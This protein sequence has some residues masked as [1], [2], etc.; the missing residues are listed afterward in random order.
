MKNIALTFILLFSAIMVVKADD[1]KTTVKSEIKEVT[2]FINGAQ[3]TRTASA[4][5]PAGQSTFV[6]KGLSQYL[7]SNSVQVKG[8]GDFT[9][10]S[11]TSQL[12]YLSSQEKSK[13][14]ITLSDSL[15]SYNTQLEYQ[16]G[17]IEV[18]A[19][20][21]NMIIA[22]QAIGG[23]DN[24]VKIEDLKA[25]AEFFR[26][27]LADIKAKELAVNA[28][29]KKIQEKITNVTNQLSQMNSEKNKPTSEIIL[30]VTSKA[31]VS[32]NFEI[33]YTV[34]G[35][36]WYPS[37]DLRA[38]DASSPITLNYR[39]NVYQTT[40][41]DWKNITLTLSSGNPSQVGTKPSL[42]PWYLYLYNPY[43]YDYRSSTMNEVSMEKSK[44]QSNGE[45]GTYSPAPVDAQ[46]AASYTTVDVNATNFEFE[47][48]L[49]YTITSD[50]KTTIVDIQNYTLPATYQYYCAPK[51]DPSAFLLAKVTGWEDYNLLSG[52]INLY[53]EG[54]YV[55]KSYLNVK[56]TKD[57]LD[58]SL[59]RD[60]NIV[61]E[62][63][64]QKEYNTNQFIGSNRKVQIAWEISVRNKKKT[65]VTIV[66]EDQLPISTD[67]QIEV[68][69]GEISDA[70]YD[71]TNGFLKWKFNL[72]S[73]E[74][75]K[76][77]FNYTVKY[78]KDK[79]VY[80]E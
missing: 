80:I 4:T 65:P 69:K 51:L 5:V 3:V 70:V 24:G 59:G 55:G 63:K 75:K 76:L 39:A 33:S 37:Y 42:Y 25:A 21:K 61:V 35:A 77:D 8:T 10:L 49:P 71:E 30:A 54:T 28:K 79:N 12:D 1:D 41:E 44:D 29:I 2:V 34:T 46:T 68:E 27:R 26:T 6:I 20:E 64:K 11:V 73:A 14:E 23:S 32:A 36:S 19:S 13:E 18:Y 72:N 38:T 52:Y 22:N 9:I 45:G 7:N 16:Q 74:T 43:S 57:T 17:L 48:S 50:G 58:F 40:G 56:D 15:E 62:R 66:I 78:P 31:K 53:F 60:E 47:I 67:K